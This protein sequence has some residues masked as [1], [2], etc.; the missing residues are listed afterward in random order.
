MAVNEEDKV[1]YFQYASELDLP[2]FLGV[3]L[4]GFDSSLTGF[5]TQCGFT[6]M[7]QTDTQGVEERLEEENAR[8]LRLEMAG[9]RARTQICQHVESD[10]FGEE[11]LVPSEGYR[12]YRL[13]SLAL[14][15]VSY[16]A[17][18]WKLGVL[19]EFGMD[20]HLM[21]SRAVVNRYLS[22]ALA[23]FGIAGF[24]GVPVEQGVVID[25]QKHSEG[26]VVFF[27]VVRNRLLTSEGVHP[28]KSNFHI[29]RLDS[30]LKQSTQAIGRDELMG[31]L[32]THCTYFSLQGLS[33]P[34]RQVI[35]TVARQ[36]D[37]VRY[38][39]ASF[40]SNEVFEAT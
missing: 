27:D 26:E 35:Q 32:S 5:L 36:F 22:W 4:G 12:V 39:Q 28:F 6:L 9:A 13:R 20:S 7:P 18:E 1:T 2:V 33:V 24:W 31:F 17:S 30:V 21:A 3:H 23:P 25:K 11:S 29:I 8:L 19:P 15:I 10:R 38:P 34:V 37:G 40:R 14:M 16:G